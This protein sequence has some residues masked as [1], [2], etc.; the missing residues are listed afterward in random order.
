[1]FATGSEWRG[2]AAVHRCSASLPPPAALQLCRGTHRGQGGRGP[3]ALVRSGVMQGTDNAPAPPPG[4][5]LILFPLLHYSAR[6]GLARP[7][8]RKLAGWAEQVWWHTVEVM[9]ASPEYR[10]Y[11]G[12][13]T[14]PS[15]SQTGGGGAQQ[16][17]HYQVWSL[18]VYGVVW[19]AGQLRVCCVVAGGGH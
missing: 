7:S 4:F 10:G 18:A 12:T 6:P 19:C 13:R 17:Y 8:W 3:L 11:S 15:L 14:L 5:L 16:S 1:M 2:C 9:M